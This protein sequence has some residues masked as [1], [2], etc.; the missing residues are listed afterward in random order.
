MPRT[1]TNQPAYVNPLAGFG[2]ANSIAALRLAGQRF[3]G[4]EIAMPS[5]S[6]VDVTEKSLLGEQGALLLLEQVLNGLRYVL[7]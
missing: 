6:Y 7:R 2:D 5:I 1:S 4:I 3:C